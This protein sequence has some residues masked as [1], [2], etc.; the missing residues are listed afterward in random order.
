MTLTPPQQRQV[1]FVLRLYVWDHATVRL[2]EDRAYTSPVWDR[3]RS[4]GLQAVSDPT[5]R[6]GVQWA[7]DTARQWAQWRIG[8]I[9]RV[10]QDWL[11]EDLRRLVFYRYWQ[12]P[13]LHWRTVVEYLHVSEPTYFRWREMTLQRFWVHLPV[14][15]HDVA[16][17]VGEGGYVLH[18][19][20]DDAAVAASDEDE[21]R[22]SP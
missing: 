14:A 15:S 5:G 20:M 8:Q 18:E 4:A 13:A 3:V 16:Q 6:L 19:P 11:N 2:G 17:W 10:Y 12:Q 1:E 22:E 21:S 9:Q 7:T